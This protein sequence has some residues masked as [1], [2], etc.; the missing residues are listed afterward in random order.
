M[1]KQIIVTT[2][3]DDGHKSDLKL[4]KLLK[5]YN[6]KGTFY[7][8]PR[9]EEFKNKDLLT[10]KQILELSKNFEIGAHTMTHPSLTKISRDQAKKEII[11][12]KSYL[13]NVIKKEI[14]CF[15]YPKGQYNT[16]IVC[17]VKKAGYI[18]A[19]TV[20]PISTKYPKDLLQANTSVH[21]SPL[22]LKEWLEVLLSSL[23]GEI[24]Y[25]PML[26][27]HDWEKI[28]K[29]IFDRVL[30]DGGVFHLWGHSW[31]IDKYKEWGKLERVLV[32]ISNKQN[33]NYL[34]NSKLI[35]GGSR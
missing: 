19:R 8:S 17:L 7:V 3:W 15:C 29:R 13:E 35:E 11:D 21:V 30:N 33:I 25:F 5:K 2:S 20:K 22:S 4:V 16:N 28:V 6:I 18:Y 32:H 12:S 10:D 23:F 31:E 14:K 9:N 24:K 27:T 26:F 34:V 1:K